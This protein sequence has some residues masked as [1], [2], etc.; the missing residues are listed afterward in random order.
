MIQSVQ[1]VIAQLDGGEERLK[2]LFFPHGYYLD[3]L[4]SSSRDKEPV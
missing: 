1:F 3:I 2:I 4:N